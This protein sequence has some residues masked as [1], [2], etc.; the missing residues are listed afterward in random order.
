M[1][2]RAISVVY[3]FAQ[4]CGVLLWWCVLWKWP[5]SRALFKA[6]AAPDSTL[7]AFCLPD[8]VILVAGSCASAFA[9]SLRKDWALPALYALAGA[10]IY[11]ALYSWGLTIATGGDGLLG[12]LLMSPLLVATLMIALGCNQPSTSP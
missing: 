9:I 1:T 8:V 6:D 3:L 11:A 12:A 4:A 2:G 5:T 7:L 10:A